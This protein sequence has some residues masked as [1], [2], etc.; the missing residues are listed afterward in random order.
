M[1]RK[2]IRQMLAAQVLSALTVS[3]CL[4][5]DSVIISRFLGEEAIAAY[6]LSNPLLLSIGAAGTLLA[7]GVQV[8]C[9]KA[10]GCG[11]REEADSGYASAVVAAAVISLV[12]AVMV[13][14]CRSFW[15]R[16]MGAGENGSLHRM[17]ADY[18]AGFSIGAPGSIGALV[19]VPF[20]Q[21]AGQSGLLIAAV[22]VMTVTDVA[23]DLLNVL[24]LHGGMFGMGLASAMSYYAAMIVGGI[25]LFSSR[26]VFRFSLRN[27]KSRMITRLFGSGIPAGV[28]M[29]ASVILVFVMNRLL[30][31]LGAEAAVAAYTVVLS[32][33]NAANCITTG[34]GGVSLTLCGVFFHEEDRSALRET[35]W[36]LCRSGALMGLGM[37]LMLLV[38]A[39]AMIALFIPQ[40][41]KT[42][43]LAVTGLRLFAAGL[44]PCCVNNALKYAWQAS[45]RIGLT[46]IVS[47]L[48]GALFP[49]LAGYGFSRIMGLDGVWLAFAAGEIMTLAAA[50]LLI[51][52]KSG[53]A[54]WRN[55]AYLL[56]KQDFG[57]PEGETLEMKI[58]GMAGV[59]EAA[60][61]AEMF[62][63]TRGQDERTARHIGLC[64]EETAGN[65][66]RHGFRDG[67]VH[68]LS[69]L[70][71]SKPDRWILRF[72]DDCRAFDPVRYVPKEDQLGIRLVM[73]FAKDAHYTC[74]MNLNNLVLSLPKAVI[75]QKEAGK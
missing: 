66:I 65:V 21:M 44:I 27:V 7:A 20:L 50:G 4:L 28:N 49:A 57:T 11:N 37:G 43:E 29:I 51:R 73:A 74:T 13:I 16:V 15:A 58:A 36:R 46:E 40:T 12:F 14:L 1:I 2:L 35:T 54:P 3:L 60:Q 6:G 67:K 71:L 55:G 31:S 64:V 59:T 23:L 62:C 48:E 19:L 22:L 10:L 5:I 24:V 75:G 63:R 56:L 32:I 25:Y 30:R 38:F 26:S 47:L 69:V 42:Q 8:V 41:G 9:S 17:T 70:L 72:R 18:L 52:R 34:T 45:D 39:P 61:R 33:G 68:H 53:T